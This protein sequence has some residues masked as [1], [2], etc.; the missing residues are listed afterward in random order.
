MTAT[1]NLR[2]LKLANDEASNFLLDGI[3]DNGS[4][5]HK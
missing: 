1:E 5:G 4:F 2:V 3:A